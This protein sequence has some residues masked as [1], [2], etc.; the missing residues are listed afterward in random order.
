VKWTPQDVV[1]VILALTIPLFYIIIGVNRALH[2]EL[3][4]DPLA[5][6]M[7]DDLTKIL[8]GGLLGWIAHDRKQP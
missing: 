3:S 7:V 1:A 8:V 6:A 4:A 5:L 2:P